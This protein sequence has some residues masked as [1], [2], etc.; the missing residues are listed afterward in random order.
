MPRR[1]AN[2]PANITMSIANP[3]RS[4]ANFS[5]TIIIDTLYSHLKYEEW[6][7]LIKPVTFWRIP[8]I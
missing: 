3:A 2:K 1:N 6:G 7:C 5:I 8:S 4:G